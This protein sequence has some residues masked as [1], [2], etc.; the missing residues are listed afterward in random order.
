[1]TRS[2][3]AEPACVLT[4]LVF[5]ALAGCGGSGR[6]GVSWLHPCNQDADCTDGFTCLCGTCARSC[7]ADGCDSLGASATCVT[8]ERSALA[9]HCDGTYPNSGVCTTTCTSDSD[10][11][12]WGS[13]LHCLGGACLAG[14]PLCHSPSDC[15][16]PG[17]SNVW[18][19]CLDAYANYRARC[20]PIPPGG[21]PC[22]E[23]RDCGGGAICDGNPGVAG[24]VSDA[25][26]PVCVQATAC[27]Q[28][29]ECTE[30]RVCRSSDSF[31]SSL[32]QAQNDVVCRAPC[33]TD[34]DCAPTDRCDSGGHCQPLTCAEC[35][36]YF[37]CATGTC[38]TPSC[39]TDKDCPG[40]YCV[41]GVCAASLGICRLACF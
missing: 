13:A 17:P 26:G 2:I 11:A 37:S 30:G 3:S 25:G 9:A 41:N 24:G 39:S 18:W 32:E 12:A 14:T 36:S 16:R 22:T 31:Q 29:A 33:T 1:M 23:D 10:C 15:P 4:A 5:T 7:A 38:V 20:G 8:P 28:D 21:E 35:P 6:T 34:P 27:T 19:T 40:G